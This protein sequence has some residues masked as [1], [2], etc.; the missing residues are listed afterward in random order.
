MRRAVPIACVC[1]L[2]CACSGPVWYALDDSVTGLGA[3]L[4]APPRSWHATTADRADITI[5]AAARWGA[6]P[7]D[8]MEAGLASSVVDDRY[9]AIAGD[10]LAAQPGKQT[11]MPLAQALMVAEPLQSIS[12]PRVALPYDGLYPGQ[13]GYALRRRVVVSASINAGHRAGRAADQRRAAAVAAYIGSLPVA[14]AARSLA[15]IGAVGDMKPVGRTAALL[16]KHDGP[17][18]VFGGMLPVMRSQDM[19]AGNLET[20]VTSRGSAWPKTYTFRM[21]AQALGALR[22]SGVDVVEIANNHVYDYSAVGF[23]D[24]MAGL[25]AAGM[26]FVGAGMTPDEAISPFSAFAGIEHVSLWALAAF[27]V[28]R[29]GFSGRKDAAIQRGQPGLLWADDWALG[30]IVESMRASSVDHPGHELDVV[31]VHAGTEYAADPDATQTELYHRLIDGGAD[32]VLGHHPHVL[33]PM[34]WYQGPRHSGLIVY[35]LGNFVFG[36]M[37]GIPAARQTVLLSLGVLD[38]KVRAIRVYGGRLTD[39]TVDSLGDGSIERYVYAISRTWR[40]RHGTAG[41]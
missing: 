40:D 19:L 7:D 5:S 18:L 8:S 36:G 13:P 1:L 14:A 33:Q 23:A 16:E 31:S 3:N 12:L 17:Q 4:P 22:A 2:A 25:R 9:Y 37:D 28:E 32:V 34:E 10:W 39:G 6:V 20:A 38:G 24:T 29:T 35:S 30:A 11:S 41:R 21:P 26:P 27:P 15:W